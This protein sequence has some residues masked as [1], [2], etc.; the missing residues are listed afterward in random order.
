MESD[1][2]YRAEAGPGAWSLEDAGAGEPTTD[3]DGASIQEPG[4]VAQR[5]W[6]VSQRAAARLA[7]AGA[8]DGR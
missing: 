3:P 7:K 4:A 5:A 6:D 1:A 8:L 2:P